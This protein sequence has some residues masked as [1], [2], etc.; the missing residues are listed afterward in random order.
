[1]PQAPTF[2]GFADPDAKFFKR[3]AKNNDRAWFQAHKAVYE[4]G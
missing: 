2:Q 4:E 1:M 3:L